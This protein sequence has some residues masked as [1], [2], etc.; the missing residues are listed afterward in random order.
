LLARTGEYTDLLTED[1]VEHAH[2]SARLLV[3]FGAAFTGPGRTPGGTLTLTPLGMMFAESVFASLAPPPAASVAVAVASVAGLPP[4]VSA[5]LLAQWSS[6]RTTVVATRELLDFAERAT[7]GLRFTALQLARDQ[8]PAGTPA[9]RALAARPGF[10]SYARKW[11]SSVGEQVAEDDR[12]EAWLLADAMVEV[13]A[14]APPGVMPFVLATAV[15]QMAGDD[16]LTVL[17]GMRESGH[18]AGPEIADAVGNFLSLTAGGPGGIGPEGID[19]EAFDLSALGDFADLGDLEE[20]DFSDLGY[21]LPKGAL[22]QLKVALRG[23]SRPAVWRRVAVPAEMTLGDL[24]QVIVRAMGWDGG[25][26]HSFSDGITE[27]GTAG[28]GLDVEDEDEVNVGFVLSVPGERL[29]YLYD[30]GDGWEHDIKLEKV[31]M[32]GGPRASAPVCVAGKG[33]CP[34]DD[35]GGSS[36][37]AELKAAMAD[38]RHEDHETLLEWL[39][40]SDPAEFDPARFS[41]TEVNE[42][43]RRAGIS[44][45]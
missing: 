42:R 10:G 27:W 17:D 34:P 41:V 21:D 23:V 24:H 45:V 25:H 20:D 35:C 40:V 38:P 3:F 36:G 43:L 12:D 29:S 44:A 14:D 5:A 30:F 2:T 11:L 33:A 26:M 13:S 32:P 37:Y 6:A 19:P 22:L 39:G 15:W 4:K 18:P 28:G 1:A 9:W 16:A 7:P 8:G 31:T